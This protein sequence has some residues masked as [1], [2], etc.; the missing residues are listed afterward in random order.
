MGAAAIVQPSTSANLFNAIKMQAVANITMQI[1]TALTASILINFFL[2]VFMKLS[3]K[4]I[5]GIVNTLQ[6]LT[7][8]PKIYKTMPSNAI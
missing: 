3:M 5:W 4:R 6:I 8:L 2:A 1:Q 7:F